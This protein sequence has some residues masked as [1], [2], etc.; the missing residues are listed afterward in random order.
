MPEE[1]VESQKATPLTS[2]LQYGGGGI[3]EILPALLRAKAQ[4][5]E[6]SKVKRNDFTKS[7]YAD[8]AQIAKQINPV[9]NAN[10]LFCLQP[11]C[12]QENAAGDVSI[13]IELTLFHKSGQYLSTKTTIPF[14]AQRA[15]K[16]K[17]D[18]GRPTNEY[19]TLKI[20]AHG[21]AGAIT[22]FRRYQY[23][24]FFELVTDDD[25]GNAA[26]AAMRQQQ[27]Q[28]P[29]QYYAP[30]PAPE[31]MPTSEQIGELKAGLIKCPQKFQ[32]SVNTWV[33][34]QLGLSSIDNLNYRR[35]EIIKERIEKKMAAITEKQHEILQAAMSQLSLSEKAVVRFINEKQSLNLKALEDLPL[36]YLEWLLAELEGIEVENQVAKAESEGS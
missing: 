30:P 28:Q 14:M 31:P 19:E 7:K 27:Y 25:D 1:Q 20:D 35:Y 4:F 26:N 15:G 21:L 22:Y 17:D 8:S 36:D 33:T 2:L 13:V 3:N 29:P 23:M 9:L 16:K 6:I 32:E 5:P 12:T 34:G 24:S 11:W 18:K 10:G